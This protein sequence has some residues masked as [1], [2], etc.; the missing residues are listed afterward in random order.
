MKKRKGLEFN[1]SEGMDPNV[2][3]PPNQ[4]WVRVAEGEGIGYKDYPMDGD[5]VA[6]FKT[7]VIAFEGKEAYYIGKTDENGNLIDSEKLKEE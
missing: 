4:H 1:K 3:K 2:K 6:A 7:C 5:A